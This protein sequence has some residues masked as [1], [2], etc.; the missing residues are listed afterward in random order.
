MSD[1]NYT[2][3]E[4]VSDNSNGQYS[5]QISSDFDQAIYKV[6]LPVNVTNPQSSTGTIVIELILDSGSHSAITHD[7]PLGFSPGYSTINWKIEVIYVDVQGNEIERKTK[8]TEQA[9]IVAMPRPVD[10][11]LV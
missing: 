11:N 10:S 8:N 4:N 3:F 5:L 1:F 6:G 7:F 2:L 9:E